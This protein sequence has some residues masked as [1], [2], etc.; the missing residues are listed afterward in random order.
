MHWVIGTS[1][2]ILVSIERSIVMVI[3]VGG[4]AFDPLDE[5]I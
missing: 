2:V 4:H 5:L 3:T 1:V